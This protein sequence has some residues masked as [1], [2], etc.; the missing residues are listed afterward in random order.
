MKSTIKGNLDQVLSMMPQIEHVQAKRGQVNQVLMA[1]EKQNEPK[2]P[3]EIAAL[4]GVM[5]PNVRRIIQDLVRSG[6][7]QKSE[8]KY[9]IIK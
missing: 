1:L 9:S 3:I 2:R 4:T 7:V 6:K 5:Q 8:N